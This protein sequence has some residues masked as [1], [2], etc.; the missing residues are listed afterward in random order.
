MTEAGKFSAAG[1]EAPGFPETGY[2]CRKLATRR[3]RFS[4]ILFS[5]RRFRAITSPLS[6]PP[7]QIG[8]RSETSPQVD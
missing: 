3:N 5:R 1:A 8:G 6:P 7:N 4:Q 2:S